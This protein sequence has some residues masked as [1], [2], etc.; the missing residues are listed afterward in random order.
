[1]LT[2]ETAPAL[3]AAQKAWQ[4]RRLAAAAR[5]DI[6]ALKKGIETPAPIGDAAMVEINLDLP[7]IGCGFRRYLVMD[8][9]PKMVALFYVPTLQVVRIDRLTFDRRAKK[10]TFGKRVM[11]S[12]IRNN[13][14]VRGRLFADHAETAQRLRDAETALA[15]LSEVRAGKR[16]DAAATMKVAA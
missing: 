2:T 15:I 14:E 11:T 13:M 9:G 8:I 4:T 16:V 1:M 3:T 7:K 6:V 12:L 10:V 5:A